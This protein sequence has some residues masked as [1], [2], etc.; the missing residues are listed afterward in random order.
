[1]LGFCATPRFGDLDARVTN[2]A[3]PLARIFVQAAAQQALDS[4]DH[5]EILRFVG[6]TRVPCPAGRPDDR[7]RVDQE[8]DR[9]ED[10]QGQ[11]Q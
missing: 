5:H 1:V 11:F 2:V 8:K 10:S 6:C 7:E 3:E 4:D 9:A